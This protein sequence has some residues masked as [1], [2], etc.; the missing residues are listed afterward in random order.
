MLALTIR[1]S[2]VCSPSTYS[3]LSCARALNRAHS[4]TYINSDGVDSTV[5]RI[6]PAS[7]AL[8]VQ[9]IISLVFITKVCSRERNAR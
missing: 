4:I 5:S 3:S 7:T 9:Y 8:A 2:Q 1:K 6:D